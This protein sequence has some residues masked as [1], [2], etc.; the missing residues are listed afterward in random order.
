MTATTTHKGFM[1][2]AVGGLLTGACALALVSTAVVAAEAPK[3]SKNAMEMQAKFD[4]A[5]KGKTIGWVPVTLGVPLADE[6]T[7]QMKQE[8]DKLGMKLV[9]RDPGWN[10]SAQLQAVSALIGEKVDVLV[11]QNPNV[12]LLARELKRANEAGIYVVQVNMASNYPGDAYVGG[13]FVRIGQA[14]GE[15][16]VKACGKGSGTSGKVQIIQGELTATASL[17]QLAGLMDRKSVV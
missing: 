13:D 3:A 1:R 10:A 14:L 2:R 17:D 11:V 6:W 7:A 8:A 12:Q 15:D 9:V 4:K 5:L 16:V